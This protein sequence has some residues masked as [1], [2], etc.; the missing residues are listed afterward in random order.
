[1]T[2]FPVTSSCCLLELAAIA[3]GRRLLVAP[4]ISSRAPAGTYAKALLQR[5]CPWVLTFDFAHG[6]NQDLLDPDTRALAEELIEAGAFGYG[7]SRPGLLFLWALPSSLPCA[8]PVRPKGRRECGTSALLCARRCE[9]GSAHAEWSAH[10]FAQCL[11]LALPPVSGSRTPAS[12][13]IWRFRV[14][15]TA[16]GLH[17]LRSTISSPTSAAGGPPSGSEPAFA[18]SVQG[19]A[20]HRVQCVGGHTHIVLRGTAPGGQSWTT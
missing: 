14:W 11:R 15:R 16:A 10:I 12:S 9:D 4:W 20:G 18:P 13:F 7:G 5:G 8:P 17:M 2:V 3:T 6:P 19:L 1:M